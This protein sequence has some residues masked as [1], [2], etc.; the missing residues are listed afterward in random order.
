MHS[1]LENNKDLI[2]LLKN[3]GYRDDLIDFILNLNDEN[4]K[5]LK[6]DFSKSEDLLTA[7]S[8]KRYNRANEYI[9]DKFYGIKTDNEKY[10]LKEDENKIYFKLYKEFIIVLL[11]QEFN[12]DRLVQILNQLSFHIDRVNQSY[13]TGGYPRNCSRNLLI[14]NK[15]MRCNQYFL[16]YKDVLI[17]FFKYFPLRSYN[18]DAACRALMNIKYSELVYK[19]Q[20]NLPLFRL[21]VQNGFSHIEREYI[22]IENRYGGRSRVTRDYF[23]FPYYFS[24][25]FKFDVADSLFGMPN[26]TKIKIKNN[27]ELLDLLLEKELITFCRYKKDS[28]IKNPIVSYL[29]K[30]D[31]LTILELVNDSLVEMTEKVKELTQARLKEVQSQSTLPN[32]HH[33]KAPNLAEQVIEKLRCNQNEV[34]SLIALSIGAILNPQEKKILEK[35]QIEKIKAT[36]EERSNRCCNIL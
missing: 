20:S 35:P 23:N 30:V 34:P 2:V 16:K 19:Y 5:S 11:N 29:L 27:K 4:F 1:R 12:D 3:N 21:L 28:V 9:L 17:T 8:E 31:R 18:Y 36:R 24:H 22:K 26:Y 6:E 13:Y 7:M 32:T 25:N 14:Y 33:A 15:H 10:S